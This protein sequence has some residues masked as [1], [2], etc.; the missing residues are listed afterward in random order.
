[1]NAILKSAPFL[2]L[3]IEEH[4]RVKMHTHNLCGQASLAVTRAL[5]GHADNVVPYFCEY[6]L[7][8]R[9]VPGEDEEDVRQELYDLVARAS[10][11]CGVEAEITEFRETT[12]GATET[13]TDHPVVA[14]AQQAVHLHSGVETP[15]TGFAGGC[16]LVHFRSLGA[17]GVVLGPGSLN[18]AH[19]PDEFVPIDELMRASQIYLDVAKRLL[20][21]RGPEQD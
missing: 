14:A 21:G 3:V 8:R 13:P 11:A 18:V 6:L 9:M 7:D 19:Q 10:E 4:E 16:D 15:I 1:M 5:G 2:N 12:G 17:A 20:T